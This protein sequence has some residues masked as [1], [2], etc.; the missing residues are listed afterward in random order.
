M[1]HY[2]HTRSGDTRRMSLKQG[3]FR[4]SSMWGRM[5]DW[6]LRND[7]N[8]RMV[9]RHMGSSNTQTDKHFS[10]CWDLSCSKWLK[11]V[12][13]RPWYSPRYITKHNHL[14]WM[15]HR[16]SNNHL[17]CTDLFRK[18]YWKYTEKYW[19]LDQVY[20]A[21]LIKWVVK[22]EIKFSWLNCVLRDDEL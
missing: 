13:F 4:I 5:E 15:K 14:R 6:R 20:C 3:L 12:I 2:F 11:C 9:V 18:I 16:W 7:A 8:F 17:R 22:R 19:K 1:K 21:W 10:G